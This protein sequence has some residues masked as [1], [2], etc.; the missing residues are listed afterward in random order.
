MPNRRRPAT[1]AP[2]RPWARPSSA[3]HPTAAFWRSLA[4]PRQFCRA[5]GGLGRLRSPGKAGPMID[6]WADLL[7]SPRACACGPTADMGYL[8]RKSG[9]FAARP[10]CGQ[11]PRGHRRP[12]FAHLAPKSARFGKSWRSAFWPAGREIKYFQEATGQI[13]ARRVLIM[14]LPPDSVLARPRQAARFRIRPRR[15]GR[16]DVMRKAACLQEPA[17]QS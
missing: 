16:K 3:S 14:R 1:E 5:I 8:P 12:I 7:I 11:L 9:V 15:L 6:N 2:S 17:L 13:S 10:R 4:A